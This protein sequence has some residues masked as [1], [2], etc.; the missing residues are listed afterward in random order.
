MDIFR[1]PEMSNGVPGLAHAC[2]NALVLTIR[3]RRDRL[4]SDTVLRWT[5]RRATGR[6]KD[7]ENRETKR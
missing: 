5:L 6:S 1:Y 2:H 4:Q 7:A 3:F